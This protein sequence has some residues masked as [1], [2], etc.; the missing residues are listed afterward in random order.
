MLSSI[1]LNCFTQARYISHLFNCLTQ[2][3]ETEDNRS[4][5]S[6]IQVFESKSHRKNKRTILQLPSFL[7]RVQLSHKHL[8]CAPIIGPQSVARQRPIQVWDQ[9]EVNRSPILGNISRQYQMSCLFLFTD[10]RQY[11]GAHTD[12]MPV[13]DPT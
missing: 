3:R 2:A 10:F 1:V 9:G 13:C 11:I 4:L 5:G 12:V 6:R 8:G 7:I